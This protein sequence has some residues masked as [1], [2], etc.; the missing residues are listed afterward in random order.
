MKTVNVPMLALFA[1]FPGAD[2]FLLWQDPKKM[3]PTITAFFD[4]PMPGAR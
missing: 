3:L 4:A 1:V 2:H